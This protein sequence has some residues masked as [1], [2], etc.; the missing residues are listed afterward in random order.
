[1]TWR[2]KACP[3][4]AAVIAEVGTDDLP[5][6]RRALREAFP[7]GAREYHPY[8]I[9]CD[10]I[11]VQLGTKPA[12]ERTKPVKPAEPVSSDQRTLFE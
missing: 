10:E 11:R 3:I 1:M 9:W 8:K 12:R 7:F 2:D 4:I 5:R 6:L